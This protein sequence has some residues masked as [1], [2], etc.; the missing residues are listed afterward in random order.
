M[1][2]YRLLRYFIF[3]FIVIFSALFFVRHNFSPFSGLAEQFN[4]F[5]NFYA[6]LSQ[7][8]NDKIQETSSEQIVAEFE[9][10]LIFASREI[11]FFINDIRFVPA[12]E[13]IFQHRFDDIEYLVREYL[14]GDKYFQDILVLYNDTVAYKYENSYIG[15]PLVFRKVVKVDDRDIILDF[16]YDVAILY[17]DIQINPLPLAVKY[18][19]NI[20][21]S[22]SFQKDIFNPFLLKLNMNTISNGELLI[23]QGRNK[24][25][26]HAVTNDLK[27]PFVFF[28]SQQLEDIKLGQASILQ[29]LIILSFP[30][31]LIFLLVLD[32]III[33]Y[34]R[35]Q[36]QIQEHK[37]RF[38][39][40]TRND[41]KNKEEDINDSLMWLDRFIGVEEKKSD[42]PHKDNK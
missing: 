14:I 6:S 30:L 42:T 40:F 2:I 18:K 37:Q 5:D 9:K 23:Q 22:K 34:L 27:Y 33:N 17:Q 20:I 39:F 32:R 11:D 3:L 8:H 36:L 38:A 7:K 25:Y 12:V 19:T 29:W 15:S 4:R 41:N 16:V 13:D 28:F 31:V 26:Y 21:A 1:I 24:L 10:I 35:N